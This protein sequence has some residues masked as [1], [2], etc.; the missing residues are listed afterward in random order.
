MTRRIEPGEEK[1]LDFLREI[2]QAKGMTMASFARAAGISQQLVYHYFTAKDD[3]SL[4]NVKKHLAAIG[5]RLDVD[6]GE[7]SVAQKKYESDSGRI[8]YTILGDAPV[9]TNNLT[10]KYIRDKV[11]TEARL[12]FLA[13]ALDSLKRSEK[14]LC[15]L[16]DVKRGLLMYLFDNDD[17]KVSM[18]YKMA[19]RINRP[20][21][22]KVTNIEPE[23][24]T[25]TAEEAAAEKLTSL[26]GEVEILE[27]IHTKGNR[28]RFRI[29][30]RNDLDISKTRSVK[31]LSVNAAKEEL[32]LEL[33]I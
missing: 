26:I 30:M 21:M 5:I 33:V 31:I 1:N 17:I 2:L 12:E 4:Y 28:Y 24:G 29:R 25:K 20:V 13:R 18:L 7:I 3:I 19:K 9:R 32:L 27:T 14:E 8:K 11:G 10:P 22:W 16:L 15:D 23:A 6:F